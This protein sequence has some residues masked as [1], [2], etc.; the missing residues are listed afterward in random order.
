MVSSIVIVIT[1]GLS[2]DASA[3]TATIP[4]WIKHDAGSW[5]DGS[6]SDKEFAMAIGYLVQHKIISAN[7]ETNPDGSVYVADNLNIPHWIKNDAFWWSEGTISDADFVSSIEYMVNQKIISFSAPSIL[8]QIS[9]SDKPQASNLIQLQSQHGTYMRSSEHDAITGH[10]SY[11]AGHDK[12]YDLFPIWVLKS[13]N[14]IEH[15]TAT[16]RFTDIDGTDEVTYV[17]IVNG[18]IKDDRDLKIPGTYS[19]EIMSIDGLPPPPNSQIYIII[20]PEN[21]PASGTPSTVQSTPNVS[22]TPPQ[23]MPALSVPQH[24]IQEATSS[25][26]AIVQFTVEKAS[27]IPASIFCDHESGSQ[28]PIGNTVVTCTASDSKGNVGRATFTVTVQDTTPPA[29]SPFNP[30]ND[31]P[32]DSGAVVYFTTEAIDLVDGPV[33]IHCDHES[34]TKF[35]M[36]ITIV[37]CTA[38]DSRGNHVSHSFKVSIT[39]S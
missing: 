32:D 4:N 3:Q 1:F 5:A 14:G 25:S 2:L 37:T 28:F 24:V 35:P 9:G 20:P 16:I 17:E 7:V 13:Q 6:I 39:K 34:G 38:D 22:S 29:I 11:M 8:S 21:T 33:T 27:P 23:D 15:K 30:H 10:S 19:F 12:L 31:T 26:G 18:V 36:G